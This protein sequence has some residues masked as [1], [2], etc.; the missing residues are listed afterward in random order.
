M[1]KPSRLPPNS[2]SD[3]TPPSDAAPA[4]GVG[5]GRPPVHSQFKPGHPGRGGRPK[6]QRNSRT[7]I[8]GFLKERVTVLEGKRQRTMTKHDAMCL[9]IV[10]A[11]VSGDDKA[12]SKVIALTM[13]A[14]PSEATKQ[15]PFTA[16]DQAVIADFLGRRGNEVQPTQPP[17]GDANPEAEAAMPAHDTEETKS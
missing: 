11:A 8:E 15:E 7:V 12:Q 14:E 10:N 3:D 13:G 6:G 9:R 5:Y 16:D 17:Q 1:T 4:Y 2:D